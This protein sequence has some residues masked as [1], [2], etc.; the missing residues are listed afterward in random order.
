MKVSSSLASALRSGSD[1]AFR[2]G[3]EEFT[4]LLPGCDVKQARQV[5][6][7]ARAGIAQEN[8]PHTD[9]VPEGRVTVSIGGAS[10][11]PG[12]DLSHRQLFALAD[13]SLYRAKND[14]RNCHVIVESAADQI[15]DPTSMVDMH[16]DLAGREVGAS[17][18]N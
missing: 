15:V 18:V 8:I 14:G 13:H 7:R 9:D 16:N 11:R 6:E 2:Y 10:M 12:P 5:A 17:S 4:I 3:G 1:K